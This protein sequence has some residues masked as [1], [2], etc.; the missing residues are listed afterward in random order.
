[1]PIGDRR[2]ALV[3]AS[4]R[5][6]LDRPVRRSL[7][8]RGPADRAAVRCVRARAADHPHRASAG[9]ARRVPVRES[10]PA[11]ARAARADRAAATVGEARPSRMP[12]SA[13]TAGRRA[14]AADHRNSPRWNRV[15]RPA[16]P[17]PDD[18]RAL[19]GGLRRVVWCRSCLPP[20]HPPPTSPAG[21]PAS[22]QDS[23]WQ[24]SRRAVVRPGSRRWAT[25][26]PSR[27]GGFR[28]ARTRPL[29]RKPRF[30]R[31][32]WMWLRRFAG[33]AR[34]QGARTARRPAPLP[35]AGSGDRLPAAPPAQPW[36]APQPTVHR[37]LRRASRLAMRDARRSA[38][39]RSAPRCARGRSSGSRPNV[40]RS[41]RRTA[42]GIA[43]VAGSGRSAPLP[44]AGGWSVSPGR[45]RAG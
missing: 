32:A 27:L 14:R 3:P 44:S 1:M 37:R 45:C 40:R 26:R 39:D 12:R 4:S 38:P 30:L 6:A 25:S 8:A 35:L 13:R 29:P 5:R 21:E 9:G 24:H 20:S 33:S 22:R 2:P 43:Q 10:H 23:A 7:A 36:S 17:K 41:G 19:S 11:A 28:P 18:R 34:R 15:R 42:E 31:R 16:L